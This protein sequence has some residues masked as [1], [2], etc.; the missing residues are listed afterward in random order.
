MKTVVLDLET[1]ADRCAMARCGYQE[2]EGAFAPWPLHRIVCA[3]TLTV[4]RTR[5]D[6]LSFDLRSYSL[7]DMSERAIAASVERA[8]ESADRIITYNGRGFD[9]P[10]LLAR[11]IL[12]DE[13]VPTLARLGHRC[14]PGLHHDL[15]EQIKGT[16]GGIKLAH[17]CATFSIPAKIG[18]VG[19]NVAELTAKEN[20][21]AIEHYCETDVIATWLASEMWESS[22]NPGYGRSRWTLLARWL[23]SRPQD[24][25]KLAAFC[26]VPSRAASSIPAA[27]VAF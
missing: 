13:H 24:N 4:C 23:R 10:V 12:A 11:A 16:G 21:S 2:E 8:A 5:T 15:H 14:R 17:L 26:E 20:W 27:E 3:S 6:D 18:A 7:K 22:E 19:D 1:I 25:P 9:I